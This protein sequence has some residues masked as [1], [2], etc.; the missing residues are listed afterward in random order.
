MLQEAGHDGQ[1]ES[2]SGIHPALILRGQRLDEGGV[3]AHV[4]QAAPVCVAASGKPP[5]VV[6]EQM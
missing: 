2:V 5:K 1:A 6:V 3:V 4:E